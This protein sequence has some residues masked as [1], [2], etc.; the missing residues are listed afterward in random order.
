LPVT[1]S[2]YF[3]FCSVPVGVFSCWGHGRS[4]IAVRLIRCLQH[5]TPPLYAGKGC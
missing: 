5:L 3:A 1:T 4:S 2:L